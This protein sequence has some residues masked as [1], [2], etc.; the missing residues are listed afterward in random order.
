MQR[1]AL[2]VLLFVS[3]TWDGIVLI[4][5]YLTFFNYLV[6]YYTCF[7]TNKYKIIN[8]RKLVKENN[9]RQ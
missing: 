1:F 4:D 8:N 9:K 2:L 6:I 7:Y 3:N 5:L